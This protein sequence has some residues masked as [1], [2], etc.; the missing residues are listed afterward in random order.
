MTPE[1]NLD[2]LEKVARLL[3]EAVLRDSRETRKQVA[4][5]KTYFAAQDDYD[6]TKLAASEK[7][8]DVA[9]VE[10]LRQ[11]TNNLNSAREQLMLSRR[12]RGRRS[13]IK[14]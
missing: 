6:S 2:R 8:D 3:Y 13:R 14:H 7:P 1:Q 12:S 9:L 5:F 4:L 10:K 11:T